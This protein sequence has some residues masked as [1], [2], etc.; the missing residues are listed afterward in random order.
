MN[1]QILIKPDLFQP[2]AEVVLPP[3]FEARITDDSLQARAPIGS[4][5]RLSKLDG[6]E[7]ADLSAGDGVLVKTASGQY[8]VRIYRPQGDGTF[9]AEA[10]NPS[11]Q[12]LHSVEDGLSILAVVVGVPYLHWCDIIDPSTVPS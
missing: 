1:H 5:V 12:P 4:V 10:T 6:P 8:A 7:I 2:G 3:I 11:C 9:L